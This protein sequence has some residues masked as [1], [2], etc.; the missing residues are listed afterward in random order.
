MPGIYEQVRQLL[1]DGDSFAAVEFLQSRGDAAAVAREYDAVV[2]DLYWQAKDLRSAIIVGRAGVCFCLTKSADG[3]IDR[4]DDLRGMAKTLAYNM[5]SFAW[6]GW[7][8]KGIDI[9]PAELSAGSDCAKLNLRLGV[10]LKRTEKAMAAAQWLCGAWQMANDQWVDAERSFEQASALWATVGDV[11]AAL[12]NQAYASLSRAWRQ[13]ELTAAYEASV[14]ALDARGTDA[15]RACA[16][17]VRIAQSVFS[18]SLAN[19]SRPEVTQ[20]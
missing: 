4:R 6:P 5:A 18:Q 19:G 3:P 15:A 12:M 11:D 13:P 10:E 17:Q 20:S 14:A 16:A 9:G 1:D 2:R 7:A 8:E